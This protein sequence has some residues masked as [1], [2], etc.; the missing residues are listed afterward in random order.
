MGWT[1]ERARC[2]KRR[3]GGDE[4]ELSCFLQP[5]YVLETCC[6]LS[7]YLNWGILIRIFWRVIWVVKSEF[8]CLDTAGTWSL[9]DL[10]LQGCGLG[11]RGDDSC[12][13]SL[14]TVGA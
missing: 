2:F 8:E 11:G 3:T 10:S 4:I 1:G 14:K 12:S 13:S 9:W 5:R 7:G 6:R